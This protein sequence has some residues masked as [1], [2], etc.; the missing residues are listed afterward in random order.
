M[1]GFSDITLLC[2]VIRV[3]ACLNKFFRKH[4]RKIKK[5]K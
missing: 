5:V 2:Y 1:Y 3:H 4:L